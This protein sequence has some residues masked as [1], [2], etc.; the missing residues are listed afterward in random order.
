MW[1]TWLQGYSRWSHI[2]GEDSS[3][4]VEDMSYDVVNWAIGSVGIGLVRTVVSS[5]AAAIALS[6]EEVT[7]IISCVG[8]HAR[9][10]VIQF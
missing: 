6:D 2:A 3:T 7:G 10:M 9:V 4:L 8:N 5:W 1:N